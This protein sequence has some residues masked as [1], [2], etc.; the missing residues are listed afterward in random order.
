[1]ILGEDLQNILEIPKIMFFIGSPGNIFQEIFATSSLEM[2]NEVFKPISHSEV[3][4]WTGD[5]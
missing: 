4:E 3:D 2:H 5:E 1:V